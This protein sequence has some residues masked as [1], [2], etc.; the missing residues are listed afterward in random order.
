[1]CGIVAVLRRPSDR[2]PPPLGDV[3]AGLDLAGAV[4]A[5]ERPI[6]ERLERAADL[7]DT[8]DRLLRGTAGL[9]TLLD[10]GDAVAAV[11]SRIEG[12]EA[13]QSALEAELDA[14]ELP[15]DL[16]LEAAS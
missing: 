1:M 2:L 6:V 4:L 9:L 11:E 16:D 13:Q 7:A 5:S 12:L 3:W 15:A 8:V 14:S 10:D